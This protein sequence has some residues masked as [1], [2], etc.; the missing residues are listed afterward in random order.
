MPVK[1]EK[2]ILT[3]S[4]QEER[5]PNCIL[6]DSTGTTDTC[7]QIHCN[8]SFFAVGPPREGAQGSL[9][10]RECKQHG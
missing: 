8:S 7:G 5:L 10:R 4:L 1:F 2:W 9:R 3:A 6:R